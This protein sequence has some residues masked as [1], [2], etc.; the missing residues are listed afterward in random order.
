MKKYETN[1]TKNKKRNINKLLLMKIKKNCKH[2]QNKL[3]KVLKYTK[4]NKYEFR[5]GANRC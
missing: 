4:I 2:E 5:N 3:I 1:S